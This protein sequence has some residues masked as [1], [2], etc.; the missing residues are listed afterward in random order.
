MTERLPLNIA[1]IALH[2][3]HLAIVAG[4]GIGWMF[5][6]TRLATLAL[7]AAIALSWVVIGPLTGKSLGYCLVTDLQW[8]VR[9][10]IGLAELPGGY[11][12]Y[13]VDGV[14][15]RDLDAARVDRW[16]ARIFAASIAG[17]LVALGVF[18]RC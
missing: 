14:T 10:G 15:G 16:T 7:Q 2:G 12:K 5:C 11:M 13:L 17:N 1:N 4:A 18:G 3:L 9:R 6:E 8:R